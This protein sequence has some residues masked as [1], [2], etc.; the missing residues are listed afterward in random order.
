[1]QD[2]V[3]AA[4]AAA[5]DA[6]GA[7]GGKVL[8][9]AG[10]GG[11]VDDACDCSLGEVKLDEGV[12]RARA[13]CDGEGA[14]ARAV[15]G[16]GVEEG[17]VVGGDIGGGGGCYVNDAK[18]VVVGGPVSGEDA[19]VGEGDE[20][21][22]AREPQRNAPFRALLN[23]VTGGDG[24]RDVHDPRVVPAAAVA[25]AHHALVVVHPLG[26]DDGHVVAA[27]D[28]AGV[29]HEATG[30]NICDM[31]LRA[32]PR[33]VGVAPRDEAEAGAAGRQAGVRVEVGGGD[34]YERAEMSGSG[35]GDEV[36]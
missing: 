28:D 18:A 27:Q 5:V 1:V 15:D 26:G 25:D 30:I 3:H 33:H 6:D 22:V 17:G 14:R 21:A 10:G 32:V 2:C 19:V 16:K 24:A 31:Q 35:H 20:G 7:G 13:S 23:E 29:G 8:G 11:A 12:V 9:R 34:G 36:A 4:A